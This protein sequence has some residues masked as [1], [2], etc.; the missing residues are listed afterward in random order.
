MAALTV[1]LAAWGRTLL[2]LT[3]VSN[4]LLKAMPL[5]FIPAGVG[6]IVLSDQLRAAW[7]PIAA[8]LLGSTL[9][10]LAATA[11]VMKGVAKL[12]ARARPGSKPSP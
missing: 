3:K 8:S 4:V 6:V 7:L 10:A 9:V 5:F 1:A 2:A 11:M 12:L